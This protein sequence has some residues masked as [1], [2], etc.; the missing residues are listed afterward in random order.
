MNR[1]EILAWLLEDDPD[2][3]EA[4][5]ALADDVR[6]KSVG[7]AVFIRGLIEFSSYCRCRCHYCGMRADRKNLP[8]YRMTAEEILDAAHEAVRRGY[9]TIVLQSGEDPGLD[10]EW[11]AEIL[12]TLKRE[13]SLAITLSCGE[14]SEAEL[15]R[16]YQA[17][18]DRYYLRFETSDRILW[19]KI[20]PAGNKDAPHRIDILPRIRAL[21]YETGS[22]ILVGIPGQTWS[23]L[24][25][26]LEWFQR[27]DLDMIGC[28]PFVPHEDT[29]SGQAYLHPEPSGLQGEQTPNTDLM[30]YKVMAL[31]RLLCPN[32]N[33]PTTT[34]L[35]TLNR[36]TGHLM[37][38][39]R[40]ANVLMVNL[41]PIQYRSLYEIYPAKAGISESAEAQ[42]DRVKTLLSRLGRT[43][44]EGPGTSPNYEARRSA[45][46]S[47]IAR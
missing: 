7:D 46:A 14:R 47:T 32:V 10:V 36:E 3:L 37:G 22:G 13:T 26:D 43:A 25:D 6:R 12:Q 44:G 21:G 38:L 4:L 1:S 41:T 15:A 19:K 16:L 24:T 31:T 23:S 20:H 42:L 40:G 29:P 34:A 30:T 8:R 27:L 45:P 35:A 18:A 11:L 2:R 28:G 39:Q 9:G 33:I 17:G 5:W